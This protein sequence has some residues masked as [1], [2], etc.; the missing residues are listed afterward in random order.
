[1]MSRC[2]HTPNIKC[3]KRPLSSVKILP[4]LD[5]IYIHPTK[6]K[7][8]KVNTENTTPIVLS[9]RPLEEV[10]S[11]TYLGSNVDKQGGTDADIR[12]RI[13]KARG[14]FHRLRNVWRSTILSTKTKLRIFNSTVSVKSVLIYGA[15]TWRTTVANTKK[16]QVYLS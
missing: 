7:I 5:W 11:L 9:D 15:E 12:I 1:M 2:S 6:S 4:A 3:R 16:L 14:V 13:G 8:L 10:D